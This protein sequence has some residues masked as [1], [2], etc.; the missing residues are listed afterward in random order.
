[1]FFRVV[2]PR[3]RDQLGEVF[4]CRL[5]QLRDAIGLAWKK[6]LGDGEEPV[7]EVDLDARAVVCAIQAFDPALGSPLIDPD[8]DQ[9]EKR[10]NVCCVEGEQR[11]DA[12]AAGRGF[13][14]G[15]EDGEDGLGPWCECTVF[16]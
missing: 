4:E 16:F 12:V 9:I 13:R 10:A 2:L 15:V 1:L 8:T 11:L 7:R 5:V 14:I 6:A 3:L